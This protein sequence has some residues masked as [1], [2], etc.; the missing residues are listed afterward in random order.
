[1]QCIECFRGLALTLIVCSLSACQMM[2]EPKPAISIDNVFEASVP[3]SYF[4]TFNEPEGDDSRDTDFGSFRYAASM[5]WH[6]HEDRGGMTMEEAVEA[7]RA[8]LA[9]RDGRDRALA[10][11]ALALMLLNKHLAD[12]GITSTSP[13]E[14]AERQPAPEDQ[15]VIG[16]AMELLI[17]NA[18]PNADLLSAGLATLDGYWPEERISTAAI[19]AA[20][21][22]ER[23][24]RGD[25]DCSYCRAK[26]GTMARAEAIEA[27]IRSLDRIASR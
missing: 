12:G 16:F 15:V 11:Q 25:D 2:T 7:A 27:G 20:R 10:E 19:I 9:T 23:I 4:Y 1:M 21:Q 3:G 26:S 14:L 6:F 24:M 22:A 8:D 17:E 18:N 5:L 13:A